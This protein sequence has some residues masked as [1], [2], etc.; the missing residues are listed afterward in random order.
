MA[1]PSALFPPEPDSVHVGSQLD[2]TRRQQAIAAGA[3]M[4]VNG[5]Q[6]V[7]H[8]CST[9]G[10][11]GSH[12]S[13]R[14]NSAMPPGPVPRSST[15]ASRRCSKS[16]PTPRARRGS[17]SLPNSPTPWA[18]P[19]TSW[20]SWTT[21]KAAQGPRAPVVMAVSLC[22]PKS[23]WAGRGR[24]CVWKRPAWPVPAAPGIASLKAVPGPTRG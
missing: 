17:P 23:A 14:P 22:L 5:G 24:S 7:F 3:Q 13:P 12:H 9:G 6:D 19:T 8:A 15:S 1:R 10:R 16:A 4:A 11:G 20:A 18:G 2:A 21:T